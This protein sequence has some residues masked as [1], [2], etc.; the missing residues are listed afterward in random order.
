MS[1]YGAYTKHSP[2][3][4]F[5]GGSTLGPNW[6]VVNPGLSKKN[7]QLNIPFLVYEC[8]YDQIFRMLKNVVP[9][10]EKLQIFVFTLF[11]HEMVKVDFIRNDIFLIHHFKMW[12]VIFYLSFEWL[13]NLCEPWYNSG[14]FSN[15][16]RHKVIRLETQRML[17]YKSLTLTFWSLDR[18]TDKILYL[19]LSIRKQGWIS[20]KMLI[21]YLTRVICG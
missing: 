2:T 3:S 9:R 4:L 11:G 18:V 7:L 16:F 19:W 15:A 12:S 1:I 21:I 20:L 5:K 8:L 17:F 10:T 14:M 13:Q 6:K